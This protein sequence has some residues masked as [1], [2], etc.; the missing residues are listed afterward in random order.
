MILT[1][2]SPIFAAENPKMKDAEFLR[3]EETQQET[4]EYNT[5]IRTLLR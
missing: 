2:R 4:P 3:V 1:R 5:R